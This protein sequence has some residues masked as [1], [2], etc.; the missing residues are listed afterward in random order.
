M[1]DYYVEEHG[2]HDCGPNASVPW[3][4]EVREPPTQDWETIR[5]VQLWHLCIHQ[6]KKEDHI[7]EFEHE[8]LRDGGAFLL[9]FVSEPLKLTGP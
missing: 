9:R 5:Y 3:N 8:N 7:D 4:I 2:K 6:E 1:R